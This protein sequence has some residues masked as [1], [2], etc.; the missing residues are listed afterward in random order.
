MSSY[1][2]HVTNTNI[3][4]IMSEASAGQLPNVFEKVYFQIPEFWKLTAQL[5]ALLFKL[6]WLIAQGKGIDS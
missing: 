4:L 5:L 2:I 1:Y 3:I 6:T